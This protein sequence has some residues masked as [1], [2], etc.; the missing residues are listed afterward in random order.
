MARGMYNAIQCFFL[1]SKPQNV[2]IPQQIHLTSL[3]LDTLHTDQITSSV[4]LYKIIQK[5]GYNNNII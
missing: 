5:R 3:L 4:A 1:S 2:I